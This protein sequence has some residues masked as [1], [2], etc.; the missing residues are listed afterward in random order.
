MVN[1][2]AARVFGVTPEEAVGKTTLELM[3]RYRAT[4]SDEYD[5]QVLA[6]G[7]ELGFYEDQYTDVSGAV[8]HWLTKKVPLLDP[9]GRVSNIVSVALDIGERKRAEEAL[10]TAKDAAEAATQAKSE[11]LAVMSH[12]IRTPMNGVL[13][14]L[15][16]LEQ[17]NLDAAQMEGIGVIR[18]SAASLL[19]IINDILDFSKLEADRLELE[20]VP[21]SLVS[22]VEGVADTLAANARV[23]DLD[24]A[25][26]V[27]PRIPALVE[28]DP[29]R[30]RQILLN[31]GSNAVKFTETG[32]VQLRAELIEGGGAAPA[33]GLARIAFRIAD[34]GIGIARDAL[35]RLFLPFSQTEISIARRFGGTG[36]GLSITRRLVELMDG[37]IGVDSEPGKGSVFSVEVALA[38]PEGRPLAADAD[39]SGLRI[40]LRLAP[41]A[42]GDDIARYLA[43]AGAEILAATGDGGA[44]ADVVVTDE[45][46]GELPGELPGEQPGEQPQDG[47]IPGRIGQTAIVL[48]SGWTA[49]RPHSVG[50]DAV[51]SR[52]IRRS[53]LINA[54]AVAA[55]RARPESSGAALSEE[56]I[57][58]PSIAQ[59]L[60]QNRLIL[61]ADDHPVNRQV[62]LRQLNVLGYAAE[63]VKDGI[64]ALK[65]LGEKPYGLLLTD[66]HMPRLDGFELTDRVR[67]AERRDGKKRLPIVAITANALLGEADRCLAAGMDGY[68]A[69]P[70]EL[71]RLREELRRWLP[72]SNDG[73]AGVRLPEDAPD[74]VSGDVPDAPPAIDPAALALLFGDDRDTIRELL[75]GFLATTREVVEELTSAIAARADVAVY[76]AA[77]KLKGSARTAGA[78]ALA[79]LGATL[80]TAGKLPDWARIDAAAPHLATELDRLER[81]IAA[82]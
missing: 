67:V 47:G 13:G 33:G 42:A 32:G 37:S 70:V 54:V 41:D 39:L 2:Y 8:R 81:Y 76:Q 28:G 80:E 68:L 12:E 58:V 9:D 35:D 55:G 36:L 40:G 27:D 75:D 30:L 53:A 57:A 66:C 23:K 62:I 43:A 15:E 72:P 14:M 46:P 10:Q 25:V 78:G 24:L 45:R 18:E 34:T 77:H 82:W 63:A 19:R 49:L 4:K 74:T 3:R 20:T 7:A 31:L 48:L 61:L 60:Q 44:A 64:D 79:E 16:I 1:R 56:P 26:F 73:P 29:V 17:T 38:I 71:S 52:P 51:V 69:K 6:S 5:R 22:V 59:A 65:A 21:V 50:V 11:F